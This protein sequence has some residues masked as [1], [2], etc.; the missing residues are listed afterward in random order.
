MKEKDGPTAFAKRHV[1]KNSAA[2]SSRLFIDGFMLRHI[3]Q[4]TEIEANQVLERDGWKIPLEELDAFISILYVR[5]VYCAKGIELV[6]L[7][8]TI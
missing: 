4:C 6:C 2:S 8:S 1:M 5:G 7:W 3:K